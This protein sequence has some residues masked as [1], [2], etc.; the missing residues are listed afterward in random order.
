MAN[1][2]EETLN[3]YL[4]LL[5]DEYDG[6]SATA[7]MRSAS[8]SATAE[9]RSASE[10]I[11]ITV[12]HRNATTAIPIL[13]EAKIGD[14]RSNRQNAARQARS[15][16]STEPHALAWGL[17]YP[18]HLRDGSRSAQETQKALAESE[19]TFAP[20][21]RIDSNI[22]WRKGTV[23]DLADTLLNTDLSQERVA[24]AILYTV[25]QAAALLFEAGC[26]PALADALAL[27][28][29]TKDLR[30][31]TLIASLMLSN[32]A[33]L[34]HRLRLVE[35]LRYVLPLKDALKK[36]PILGQ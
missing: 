22:T 18:G 15:R 1:L 21:P 2:R 25:R 9:M 35:H 6:I 34:H 32:A 10:A 13:I 14:S 4:A 30:A 3:T 17:C 28:K 26:A 7:E 5:L 12:I 19:I 31:A 29:T 8:E 27:P 11:D 33:L 23:A 24:D 36:P 20:V 16:L